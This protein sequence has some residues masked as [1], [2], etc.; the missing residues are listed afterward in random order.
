MKRSSASSNVFISQFTGSTVIDVELYS[1]GNIYVTVGGAG[2]N[3]Y[4]Y[5][6]GTAWTHVAVVYDG[7]QSSNAQKLLIYVDDVLQTLTFNGT[8][9]ASLPA[10]SGNF[11]I[12][13]TYGSSSNYSDGAVDDVRV[14]SVP[15]SPL[16]VNNIYYFPYLAGAGALTATANVAARISAVLTGAG[17]LT[18]TFAGK[19]YVSANFMGSGALTA[20]ANASAAVSAIL[21]GA[22]TLTTSIA[23]V[24][25]A[26]SAVM[27]G[28]G[29]LA[30]TVKQSMAVTA[31]MTGAG[32]LTAAASVGM[33]VQATMTGASSLVAQSQI[34][35]PGAFLVGAG[36]LV[37]ALNA[38]WHIAANLTGAGTL[39]ASI[40]GIGAAVSA[41]FAGS[42]AL[43]SAASQGMVVAAQ[44]AGASTAQAGLGHGADS[45]AVLVG[46]GALTAS[47]GGVGRAVGSYFYGAGSLTAQQPYVIFQIS[48]ILAGAGAISAT[49]NSAQTIAATFIGAGAMGAEPVGPWYVTA[50]F[51]GA[52]AMHGQIGHILNL[53]A[54]FAG[55]GALTANPARAS[56]LARP[57]AGA[58]RLTALPT[59]ALRIVPQTFGGAGYLSCNIYRVPPYAPIVPYQGDQHVRRTANDYATNFAALFP[60]GAAW[61]RTPGSV[62]MNFITSLAQIFGFFDA[63]AAKLLETESDPRQTVDLLPDWNRNWGLPDPCV[64]EGLSVSDQQKALVTKMTFMGGQSRQFFIQAAANIGYPISITE[65]SPYTCGISQC[66]DTRA[67]YGGAYRW[68]C[69][70]GTIRYYWTVNI[71]NTRLTWFR[72]GGGGGQC[73]VDPSLRF[74]LATDL[75]CLIQRWKPGH[76]TVIFSFGNLGSFGPLAGTP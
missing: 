60:T 43:T 19:D 74:S 65:Y 3:G 41:T 39:T 61:A 63:Q 45:S 21:A 23:G 22:G 42:G 10:N 57:M 46:A 71:G 62:F 18:A 56:V 15:I 68:Q 55:A 37:A 67:T 5:A 33:A 51:A 29:A 30:A 75:E 35:N 52:G 4:C 8:L 38:P 11:Y 44:M 66:G 72:C 26:I 7:T 59:G 16:I 28:S 2:I 73:G 24:G 17:G 76:T 47:I 64:Q 25:R 32:A 34:G 31:P 69:G 6:P 40:A 58:G 36:N 9:P 1:D 27:A 54:T 50:G 12:G 14:F 49:A 20:T 48:A 13:K 70:A 53:S